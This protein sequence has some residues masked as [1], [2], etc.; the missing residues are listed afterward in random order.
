MRRW[1]VG[2]AQPSL[3]LILLLESVQS[4]PAGG[5]P[6]DPRKE[7]MWS[8]EEGEGVALGLM[9]ARGGVCGWWSCLGEGKQR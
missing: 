1:S 5:R 7:D 8:D 6:G 3:S 2:S 4:R 9:A